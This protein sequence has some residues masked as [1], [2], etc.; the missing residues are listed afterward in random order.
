M[1]AQRSEAAQQVLDKIDALLPDLAQ[2]AQS[3][4]DARRIPAEVADMLQETGFFKLLQPAQWGGHETD[5]VTFYE[6]VRRLAT[7]CGSTGWVAGIVGVHNWH[8]ALFSQQA[9]EDVWGEDP[10]VRISSSYAPMGM[11][12]VVDGGY[13]VNGSWAWSSG[14]DIADWVVVGGP[15]IKNGKPVDFVSF[16][17]PRTDYNIKDVWNVVGLRGTGSNTIE[18]KDVFV[19]THR[20]LSFGVM[21]KGAAPG[22]ERNTAPVY[23]MPWGTIH[24]ST[25]STPIVGMAYGAYAAHV[26]HQGKRVRAAY[27]G[28]KAKDDPFA[29]VR[30]AEAASDID[31]A[32]RQLSGNLQAE[33]DLIVAGEEVPME[34]RLAARRDQV[35]ATSRAIDSIDLLF[36]NSGAHALENGTPIQRFWR[37]AHAGRVHAANDPERAYQ[38]FGNGEFGI[39]IGDTMV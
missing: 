23:K 35:R 26:E 37:D 5:P 4:E 22:L 24:P 14:C 34:L 11:G 1:S 17:I 33:Y 20:V 31:A 10:N 25:I 7:A 39:P 18:V 27:A 28:E 30:I 29:K 15:V 3:T 32:W 38:A 13:K 8:L 6:A 21:S 19:P 16:L 36:E 9:Q 2:R 12:E